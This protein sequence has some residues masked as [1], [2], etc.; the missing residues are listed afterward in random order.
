[1][2]I[3][4]FFKLFRV[5]LFHFLLQVPINSLLLLLESSWDIFVNL[6]SGRRMLLGLLILKSLH[7]FLKTIIKLYSPLSQLSLK[8]SLVV[9]F[10][11]SGSLLVSCFKLR[12]AE[13][14]VLINSFSEQ[15]HFPLLIVW[16]KYLCDFLFSKNSL[17]FSDLFGFSFYLSILP[18]MF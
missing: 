1:M 9:N 17:P 10:K 11:L 3:F 4:L 5:F 12:S 13:L 15:S 7:L 6:L 16:L 18:F 2:L 8:L 14:E